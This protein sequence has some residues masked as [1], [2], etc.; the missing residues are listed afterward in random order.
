MQG[1][2]SGEYVEQKAEDTRPVVGRGEASDCLRWSPQNQ[3]Q[4][5]AQNSGRTLST[6]SGSVSVMEM[7]PMLLYAIKHKAIESQVLEVYDTAILI[8][9]CVKKYFTEM[10]LWFAVFFVLLIIYNCLHR[11]WY[12][13]RNYF[14]LIVVI[15]SFL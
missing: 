1:D 11:A 12:L 5:P 4:D 13:R 10:S 7:L 8:L 14:S 15:I 3:G 6:Q 2:L 9:L